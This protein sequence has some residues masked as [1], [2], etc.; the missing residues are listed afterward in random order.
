[1]FYADSNV[2]ESLKQQITT[3]LETLLREAFIYKNKKNYG[4][5]HNRSDPPLPSGLEGFPYTSLILQH[6]GGGP[7]LI[8][9]WHLIY[10]MH[11]R[12]LQSQSINPTPGACLKM[13]SNSLMI[14]GAEPAE[15]EHNE[16][17]P[18]IMAEGLCQ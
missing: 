2:I 17:W 18:D 8:L 5:F 16:T 11:S 15:C 14:T 3:N 4:K 6:S 10:L 9:I 13:L 12:L 1:M 7:L